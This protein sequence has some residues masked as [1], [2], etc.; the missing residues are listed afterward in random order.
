MMKQIVINIISVLSSKLMY[1]KKLAYNPILSI[2]IIQQL[3]QFYH[4]LDY[5]LT[6]P[7]KKKKTEKISKKKKY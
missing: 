3:N 6:I 1:S 7:K 4:S 2:S 5:P